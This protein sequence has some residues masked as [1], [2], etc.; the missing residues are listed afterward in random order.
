[1]IKTYNTQQEYAAS[2]KS[3]LESTLS[4]IEEGNLVKADGVNVVT[5]EPQVGDILFLDEDKNRVYVKGSTA[6]ASLI[7]SGWTLVGFVYYR[8][9]EKVGIINK[10]GSSL[11]YADVVQFRVTV[12]SATGTLTLGA[13][14]VTAGTTTSISVEYTEGMDLAAAVNTYEANDTT[15]CGRINTA[16]AALEGI[17]GDW[18]AYKNSDG[19]V[20]L[21]RDTWTDYRQYQCSGALTHITWGDMPASDRYLKKNGLST[22]NRGIMN[23]SG[24]VSYWSTNGRAADTLTT[25]EPVNVGGN[26][27]PVSLD[28][29]TNSE[30]CA[31]I[32]A[33][34]STY[35]NYISEG[36]GIMYPQK[37]GAFSLLDGKTLT[38]TYGGLTAP[39]KA[40]STKAKFPAM[41]ACALVAYDADGLGIG[42]WYLPGVAEGCALMCDETIDALAVATTKMG[43]EGISG[44]TYRWFSQRYSVYGGWSFGGNGRVLVYGNVDNAYRVQ[45][46]TL[47]DLE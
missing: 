21:Q 16:L 43:A 9:G 6:K 31:D 12:P 19:D 29:F 11:K 20:I 47:L 33:A 46:V 45:G 2:T 32:R 26:T 14:F 13:Q 36:Y 39:T 28:A 17:T 41:N 42:D 15:L 8:N 4:L 34:Y 37:Y 7:P 44:A 27:N 18:W 38:S 23:V 40:G 1:M 10:T 25:Q 35:K 3:E 22:N 24:G 5:V 30:Y